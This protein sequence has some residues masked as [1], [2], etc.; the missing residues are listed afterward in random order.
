MKSAVA[1]SEVKKPNLEAYTPI[2]R[3]KMKAFP[4]CV[5]QYKY[6]YNHCNCS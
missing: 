5:I 6:I 2:Y 4:V 1:R 3:L